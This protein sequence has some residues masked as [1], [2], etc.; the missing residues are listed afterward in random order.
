MLYSTLKSTDI[1]EEV[2]GSAF[3]CFQAGF[4]FDLFFHH[5]DRGDIHPKRRLTF[6]RLHVDTYIPEDSAL[7]NH[8]CEYIKSYR[9]ASGSTVYT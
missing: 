8:R 3:T 1:S 5:K 4:L 9:K 6:N 2:F 7:H